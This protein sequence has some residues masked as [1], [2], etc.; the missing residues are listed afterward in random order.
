VYGLCVV[1]TRKGITENLP[2]SLSRWTDIPGSANKWAWFLEQLKQGWMTA[3]D[4]R[5]SIPARWSLKPE[6]T[7]GLIFWTKDPTN[8]FQEASRLKAYR[9]KVHVTVTGWEEVEKGAP[10]LDEGAAL[11]RSAVK[12]FGAANVSWRFS[13]IPLV[14]DA[15]QRFERIAWAAEAAGLKSVYV[16]FLQTNELLPET[17]SADVR[18]ALL[19]EMAK[20]AA[21]RRIRVDLCN[22]DRL[23]AGQTREKHWNLASGVCAPPEDFSL[24]N[25]KVPPAEGCGCVMA[26]DPFTVNESCSFGCTYCYAADT[27]LYTKKRNTTKHLRV[28]QGSR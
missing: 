12:I 1:N 17:R 19:N 13:P 2:Y 16:S 11:L 23:L 18:R 22:E 4:Q 27:S 6:D 3:F 14:E 20:M 24:S 28:L 8:L 25:R 15:A 9:T 7:L 10:T 21:A 26:V 5:T